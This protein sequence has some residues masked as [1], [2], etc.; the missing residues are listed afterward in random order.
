[1]APN[2]PRIYDSVFKLF[3]KIYSSAIANFMT[4]HITTGG[5][6]LVNSITNVSLPRLMG[7]DMLASFKER[8]PEVAQLVEKVPIMVCKVVEMGM[9]GA[10]FVARRS[11]LQQQ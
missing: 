5:M 7:T 1:M 6:Y 3:V 4:Q 2:P 9:K 11:F 10:F 8:H